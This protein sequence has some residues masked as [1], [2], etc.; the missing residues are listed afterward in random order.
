MLMDTS[1]ALSDSS[2]DLEAIICGRD[3]LRD[4]ELSFLLQHTEIHT[5]SKG[6]ILLR[7]GQVANVCYQNL[8]G[9][10]REYYLMDGEERTAEFY[11]EG[12]SISSAL[13]SIH[14][15]PVNHYWECVEDTTVSVFTS[16]LEK[17]MFDRFPRL[18]K[19]CRMS[20]EIQL[21]QLREKM[22][23]LLHSTPKQRYL[24]LL[25]HRPELLDRVPQYQLASF[26][27]I[28]PESLSRIRRRICQNVVKH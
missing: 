22:F 13:S 18:E 3:V 17:E 10:V 15:I 24:H 27:G 1:T 23:N 16:R 25:D 11:T 2:L 12:Q 4:A 28:K 9:C 5:F 21:G 7:P 6:T 20:M 26:I 19:L 14:R 8:R